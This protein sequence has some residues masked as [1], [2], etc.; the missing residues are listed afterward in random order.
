VNYIWAHRESVGD[1]NIVQGRF[2]LAF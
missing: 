1:S 2:Q